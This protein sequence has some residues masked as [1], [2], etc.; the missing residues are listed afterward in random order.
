VMRNGVSLSDVLVREGL[1]R[2]PGS[3]GGWC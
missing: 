2:R 3:A 1:A